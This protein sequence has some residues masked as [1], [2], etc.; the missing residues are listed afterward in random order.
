L[1]LVW[2]NNVF[3]QWKQLTRTDAKQTYKELITSLEEQVE[4]TSREAEEV[5][6]HSGHW[7]I[8]EKKHTNHLKEMGCGQELNTPGMVIS[9]LLEAA[10]R[11]QSHLF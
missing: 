10:S 11:Y 5:P 4:E 9:P 6:A 3:I 1:Y 2:S 7:C 8:R